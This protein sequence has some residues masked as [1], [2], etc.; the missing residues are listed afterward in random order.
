MPVVVLLRTNGLG[1]RDLSDLCVSAVK[2]LQL[3]ICAIGRDTVGLCLVPKVSDCAI[4]TV[5]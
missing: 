3:L 5:A 4:S 2:L 1:G